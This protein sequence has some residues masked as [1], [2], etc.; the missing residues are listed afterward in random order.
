MLDDPK[1]AP[2]SSPVHTLASWSSLS[3]RFRSGTNRVLI[4]TDSCGRSVLAQAKAGMG[5]VGQ[6]R[7][8]ELVHGV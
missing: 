2:T 4:T 8:A 7:C 3:L 6:S 1:I 5:G